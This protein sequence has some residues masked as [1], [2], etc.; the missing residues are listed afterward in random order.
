MITPE[1][2]YINLNRFSLTT[3]KEFQNAVKKL[4][5]EGMKDLILDLRSNAG[6]YM[7]PA[8]EIS[9]EF[10]GTGKIYCLHRRV[11]KQEGEF[12]CY[13]QR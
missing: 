6:G 13:L 8:I 11:E 5:G 1:V 10:L 12:F 7:S 2:G 4:K 9:D 3:T